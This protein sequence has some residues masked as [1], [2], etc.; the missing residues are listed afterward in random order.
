MSKVWRSATG[1][2]LEGARGPTTYADVGHG[3]LPVVHG[4]WVR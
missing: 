3:T 1:V 2:A 4:S